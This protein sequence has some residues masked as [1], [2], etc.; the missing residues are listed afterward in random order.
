MYSNG[1]CAMPFC[2]P[3]CRKA[4]QAGPR[5]GGHRL[6]IGG[7]GPSLRSPIHLGLLRWCDRTG[8]STA[9]TLGCEQHVPWRQSHSGTWFRHSSKPYWRQGMGVIIV[10][11][12]AMHKA[13]RWGILQIMQINNIRGQWA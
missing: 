1:G 11:L 3:S 12:R 2:T 9:R 6:A 7:R 8:I 13:N 5:E 10:E 4:T